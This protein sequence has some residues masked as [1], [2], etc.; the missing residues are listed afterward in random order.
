MLC[1]LYNVFHHS[2]TKAKSRFCRWIDKYKWC[3]KM[4]L[5]YILPFGRCME[6]SFPF[7]LF[8]SISTYGMWVCFVGFNFRFCFYFISI[9]RV[10]L[11]CRINISFFRIQSL[12]HCSNWIVVLRNHIRYIYWFVFDVS[13]SVISS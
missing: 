8:L 2:L 9:V 5:I 12:K 3:D 6:M 7:N 13:V 4:K 11:M 1:I 10:G